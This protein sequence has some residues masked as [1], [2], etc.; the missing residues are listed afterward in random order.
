IRGLV[1]NRF[2]GEAGVKISGAG[3]IGNQLQGCYLG[4]DVS[5]TVARGNVRGVLRGDFVLH[6]GAQGTIVGTDGDGINDA[7]ERNIISG[8]TG[9]AVR[10]VFARQNNI[11][12]GNYI[13][14]DAAGS[15][16]LKNGR[17][18]IQLAGAGAQ[19]NRIGI[20]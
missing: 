17:R 9:E 16:A 6:V 7:A 8:N 4:T 1:I 18:G 12:A 15:V 5:G 10:I 20:D 3:A 19:G 13:G 14:T 2:A 11:V